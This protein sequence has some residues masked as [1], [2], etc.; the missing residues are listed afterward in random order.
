MKKVLFI[1][2]DGT[3]LVEPSDEQID[4]LD[5]MQ[6]LPGAIVNL[7]KIALELDY[8]LVMVSNQDGLGT[9][10]FP[11]ETFRPAQNLM[12]SVLK[13]AGVE[14]ADILIDRTFAHEQ[15][16]TRKPSK[17]MLSKYLSGDYDLS[18]CYVI[19]DRLSDVQLARN[20]GARAILIG[21]SET[22]SADFV[23][24]NWEA[25]YDYLKNPPRRA[26]EDRHTKETAIRL[27][28]NLDG[29]GQCNLQ[30]GIGFF[31]HM[32]DLLARHSGFDLNGTIAGDLHVDEHHLVEDTALVLGSVFRKA[33]G[34]KRG[35]ERYGFMGPM[36][37]ALA[38]VAIDLSG[39][40]TLI[41]K[42]SFKREKIGDMPTELFHH[43]FKSF[44]DSAACTIHIK[45]KG[46][47]EHHKIEAVF[48]AFARALRMAV[49]RNPD[50]RSVPSTK[51]VI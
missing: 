41:W 27:E 28:M 44:A 16:P 29:Q 33:L 31:D 35:I 8:E 23:A 10:S 2:R 4:H 11:E 13:S 9:P 6:F 37:E 21:D 50:D 40:S 5:K 38:R 47:N 45:S 3:I 20:L 43:F 14:F 46:K 25:I 49:R 26:T 17:A 12:L 34:D 7:H 1:D 42:V 48:K 39:R 36:D 19:G 22:G 30:S 51:G 15:T 24:T 32:L 18:A